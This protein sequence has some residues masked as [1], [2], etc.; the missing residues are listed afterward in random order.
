MSGL[1]GAMMTE[2]RLWDYDDLLHY[3]T[4]LPGHENG[5]TDVA[6]SFAKH[7]FAS[8]GRDNRLRIWDAD[9]RKEVWISEI[10]ATPDSRSLLRCG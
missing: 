6:T 1:R 5:V 9:T 7:H 8:V 4:Y 10:P 3:V 2:I